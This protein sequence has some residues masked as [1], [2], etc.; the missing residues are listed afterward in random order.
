MLKLSYTLSLF[1]WNISEYITLFLESEE[2]GITCQYF[3]C[4]ILLTVHNENIIVTV[5][6]H[7]SSPLI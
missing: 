5:G 3:L 2:P 4:I 6:N 7:L 1:K